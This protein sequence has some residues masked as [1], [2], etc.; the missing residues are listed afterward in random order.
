M[1]VPSALFFAL[2]SRNSFPGPGS[3]FIRRSGFTSAKSLLALAVATVLSHVS[4]VRAET[5]TWTPTTFGPFNWDNA[6]GQS[7]WSLPAFPNIA[8][9]VANLTSSLVE[10]TLI[11]LNVP[12]T[13]GMLNI[14]SSG[15]TQTFTVQS[16]LG[17]VLNFDNGLVNG[18]INQTGTSGGDTIAAPIST[19]GS[20]NISNASVNSLILNGPLSSS[21][22]SGLQNVQHLAGDV[23]FTGDISDGVGGGQIALVASGTGTMS[24]LGN[25][26][27]TGGVTLNSGALNIGSA[28]ALGGIG[29]NLTING[30]TLANGGFEPITL[31]ND[32]NQVWAGDFGFNGT[33]ALDLGAGEVL[34]TGTRQIDVTGGNLTVSSPITEA[35]VGF[36]ITKAGGGNLILRAANNISG[37]VVVN[38]GNL[39]IQHGDA[40]GSNGLV[41]VNVG[42][43]LQLQGGITVAGKSLNLNGEGAGASGTLRS[44]SGDNTWTGDINPNTA[45]SIIRI[46]ADADTLTLNGNIFADGPLQFVFQGNGNGVVNGVISGSS[47][48]TRSINGVGVWTLNA[49]NT[50]TGNTTVSN[51]AFRLGNALAMQNTTLAVNAVNGLQF[52]PG[53][54]IFSIAALAGNAVGTIVLADTEGAAV[55]LQVGA[56]HA[57]STSANALSGP[58]VLIKQGGGTLTLTGASTF[59]GG[60][61]IQSG[62][63]LASSTPA[64]AASSATVGNNGLGAGT[65]LLQGD[66]TL[67]LRANGTN[68]GSGQVIRFGNDVAL[69]ATGNI[70]VDRQGG[71]GGTNKQLAMGT[72]TLGADALNVTSGNGF[73]LRFD[74]ANLTGPATINPTSTTGSGGVVIGNIGE[75]GGAWPLFKTGNARLSIVGDANHTGGTTVTAGILQIGEG[76]YGGNLTGNVVNDGNV[77]FNRAGLHTYAGEISSIGSLTKT[78]SGTLVLTGANSYTGTTTVTNGTLMLDYG[79][80]PSVLSATTA[81][82]LTGALHI[83]GNS[84]GTT[85]QTLG[86]LTT[87]AS[88]GS[89]LVVDNNGGA[90]T[91]LTLADAWTFGASST[92]HIDLSSGGS[93]VSNPVV[94]NGVVTATNGGVARGVITGADGRTYFA[95]VNSGMI[96][97]QTDLTPLPTSGG[98]GNVNYSVSGDVVTTGALN[99][100]TLRIDTTSG[101]GS[102]DL[103]GGNLIFGRTAF[104]MDGPNDFEIKRTSGTGTIANVVIHQ[105]GAGA[106]I[107][108]APIVTGGAFTKGGP[109]LLIGNMTTGAPGSVTIAEGVFRIGVATAAPT[110][111]ITLESGILELGSGDFIGGLGTGTGQVRLT[112]DGGFSAYGSPRVVNLGGAGA[113]IVWDQANFLPGNAALNLSSSHSDATLDFQN[114]LLLG[115]ITR[116]VRV[117][118]GSANV[119]AQLSGIIGG[120]GGL[121]KT[122][123]GTL[124]LT[125]ANP[126]TGVVGVREGALA[127]NGSVSGTVH[128]IA[129][130]LE[131]AGD[132]FT[133][134][135]I[136]GNV[137]IGDGIGAGDAILSPGIDGGILATL[138]SVS[139]A[140]DARFRFELDSLLFVS[141]QMVANGM[142]IASGAVFQALELSSFSLELPLGT[143]FLALN[144][145]SGSPIVGT[146]ANLAEGARFTVGV[147]TFEAT[148]LGGDGNDLQFTAVVP[149]PASAMLL[150]GGMALVIAGRRGERRTGLPV[151]R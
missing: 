12:I 133:T 109:G 87:G 22:T 99:T 150:L 103:A 117:H 70:S 16:G 114:P 44:L 1:H 78:G 23:R 24:L 147:N 85:A 128:V 57:S 106:L 121:V 10:P 37:P 113:S 115:G 71:S 149:E 84:V 73:F 36:G 77:T 81:V 11:D 75:T 28:T 126:F 112:A 8:G 79:T 51:G 83:K 137:M 19:A 41:T 29:S 3:G 25:N 138:G 82:T 20:L 134:G 92:L 142:S 6:G 116:T 68:D 135:L 88:S 148:Y 111:S 35:L 130:V 145:M 60:V 14:G 124:A 38:G 86:A 139:F 58:G 42:G 2:M 45:G 40:L 98:S 129:G 4:E 7:N 125:A 140:S 33:A 144:N 102:L 80:G 91:T 123:P 64:V 89:K 151:R 136:S 15:G 120:T 46:V 49:A 131:G 104:L 48:V 18:E 94:T 100:G 108:S 55:A 95:T 9:D 132:G 52:N 21:A 122:G 105:H 76:G 143:G 96:V 30:G 32:H 101:P 63:V 107:Y 93:I 43:T 74:A 97:P 54:G 5:Y 47:P 72:L 65:A 31:V 118:D 90:G 13:I 66:T 69:S 53:I 127:I 34:I 17:G 110:G 59:T 67:Q 26:T 50:Y 56:N 146:F 39:N 27:F 141:G 61:I 62:T 119:D